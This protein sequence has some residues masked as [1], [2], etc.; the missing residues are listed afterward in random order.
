[1]KGTLQGDFSRFPFDRK[2][3]YSAVHM[4]Q[5]RVQLDS[6][7]NEQADILEDRIRTGTADLIGPSG[8]PAPGGYEVTPGRHGLELGPEQRF[9]QIGVVPEGAGGEQGSTLEVQV[10]PRSS[11]RILR[12]WTRREGKEQWEPVYTLLLEGG[13]LRF[14][15]ANLS[16]LDARC[17]LDGKLHHIAV[18]W[19]PERTAL[20]LDGEPLVADDIGFGVPSGRTLITVGAHHK[21]FFW[22]VFCELRLWRGNRTREDLARHRDRRLEGGEPGL[23]GLW[24]F[25]EE[26]GGT[27]PDRSPAG[28]DAQVGGA[29]PPPRHLPVDLHLGAGRYYVDGVLCEN[30]ERTS[31]TAQ[32]DLP[33]APMPQP[34][35]FEREQHILYLDVWERSITAIEDPGVRETALGGPDTA[36]RS[37]V[38]TQVRSVRAELAER[39]ARADIPF[40]REIHDEWARRIAPE[41]ARRGRLQARRRPL[42]AQ[43][44][45]NLLYRIEVHDAGDGRDTA[46]QP[47]GP[48]ETRTLTLEQW[49]DRDDA[50]WRRGQAVELFHDG[51]APQDP[52]RHLAR[53]TAVDP[54]KHT[55][56]LDTA[57]GPAF[58][59][60]VEL[61]IRRIATFK[62][63]RNN[64]SLVFPIQKMDS[65]SGGAKLL[66]SPRGTQ[67]LKR[68]DWVELVDDRLALR[69]GA[70][71]LSRIDHVD[72][73]TLQV[74]LTPKPPAGIGTDPELHPFLR[75]WDQTGDGTTA[76]GTV[77]ATGGWQEIEAGIEVKLAYDAPYRTG[78]YW[79]ITARTLSPDKEIDWPRDAQG[80]PRLLPPHGVE[81]LFAP[82]ALLTYDPGGYH[83]QDLRK[84]FQPF[85]E[86]AV[87]KAGDTMYG[88]LDLQ[89]GI[90]VSGDLDVTGRADF[91]AI[92]GRLHSRD[93][94]HTAQLANG[95]VTP[96]KLSSAVGVV[97]EGHAVL[98][99]K[100]E[101]PE[102]YAASGWA[103]TLLH[104][105]PRWVDRRP[106]PGGPPGPLVSA[107]A[108]G[109]VYIFL[110]SGVVWEYDPESNGWQRRKDMPLPV[111]GFAVATLAGKIHVA[112]GLEPT[113]RCSARHFEYDPAADTWTARGDLLTAR[114]ALALAACR[115]RLHALGGVRDS[116][117]GKC[118]TARHE[119]YDPMTDSWSRRQ[120]LPRRVSSLGAATVGDRIN[121]VGGELRAIQGRGRRTLTDEHH[122][123]HAAVDRWIL[124]KA[125]LPVPRRN[126]GLVEIYGRLYAVGGEG[127]LGWLTDFE[128]YD[129]ATD[130]WLAQAPLHEPVDF[131]GVASLD[132]AVYVTG[133]L[134]AG[135]ALVEECRVALRLHLHRRS[136][137]TTA[138][139]TAASPSAVPERPALR[140]EDEAGW[141]DL[142][143]G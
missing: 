128:A 27:I 127:G 125:P 94:V 10:L 48:G 62:W 88:R 80:T 76:W 34:R 116:P 74:F 56:T 101:A 77:P 138:V 47:L 15:R 44:L 58:R 85:S 2:K 97:P 117:S 1:M 66:P 9:V 71:P 54:G 51:A 92:Y 19:G 107:A 119:A 57:P 41:L 40:E 18:T 72:P 60:K 24:R 26:E 93:A 73:L 89:A 70:E 84:I 141:E 132:G 109:K 130:T 39:A 90:K 12:G 53:V 38:V 42:A 45:D 4:Q 49:D 135:S 100:T 131:P 98:G 8:S 5:G 126:V 6:D 139:S 67:N 46:V 30:P 91:G 68:N 108:G 115:G 20:F 61:R 133:A 124:G 105:D 103:L 95:A 83:L 22:G 123:Y 32:P 121:I 118:V 113:G 11:G 110:E 96:E 79:W 21:P 29:G 104:E 59:T 69:Q 36:T 111:R 50:G 134:R 122:Q 86:G 137:G 136:G 82:L 142:D 28:N 31:L 81:R 16:D 120:P 143:L 23:L 102:G 14:Q 35:G 17:D 7:W 64:G 106:M 78:D 75:L 99:P 55:L 43:K 3:R 114:T 33:G 25:D 63:S 129:P 65:A 140:S 87:S 112:G 37:R 52:P 13:V